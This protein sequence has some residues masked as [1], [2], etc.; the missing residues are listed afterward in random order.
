MRLDQTHITH[1]QLTNMQYP[2]CLIFLL[3]AFHFPFFSPSNHLCVCV[4]ADWRLLDRKG[5]N[6]VAL[7]K[8]SPNRSFHHQL[9]YLTN[10]QEVRNSI[11]L[12][13]SRFLFLLPHEKKPKKTNPKKQNR[14]TK[15]DEGIYEYNIQKEK[16]KT[17]NK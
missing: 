10:M 14:V 12:F 7:A 4:G 9:R 11:Y 3:L 1:V 15:T 13:F 8:Q 17:T 6:C 2:P 5:N 16:E